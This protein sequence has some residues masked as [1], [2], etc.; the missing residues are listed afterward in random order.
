MDS[1][2]N[3]T[4]KEV[5]LDALMPLIKE[6]LSEGKSITFMPR[7]ISMLP[8]L[9]QGRDSVTISPIKGDLKRFD[10]PLYQRNDGKYVLHR[11]VKTGDTYTCIGDNQFVLEKGLCKEQMIAVVT[12]FTRKGKAHKVSDAGYRFYV[13]FWHYSR[14]VRHVIRALKNRLK[15]LLK[16]RGR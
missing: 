14:P 1:L 11:I 6:T 2:S 9:K 3:F 13:V 12:S 15:R 8:M 5:C 7:G 10:I 4:K 16:K